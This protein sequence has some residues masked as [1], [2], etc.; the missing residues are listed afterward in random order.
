MLLAL[1]TV[2]WQEATGVENVSCS[3]RTWISPQDGDC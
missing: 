1:Y 2:N 3:G